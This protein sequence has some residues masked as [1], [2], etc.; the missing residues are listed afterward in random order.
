[1]IVGFDSFGFFYSD[2]GFNGAAPLPNFVP[3]D[4]P[5]PAPLPFG[6]SPSMGQGRGGGFGGGVRGGRGGFGGRGF[7]RGGGRG[8]R[9]GGRGSDGGRFGSRVG[10]GGR[11]GRGELKDMPLP[12][13]GLKGLIP[14]EKNFYVESAS[15]KAMS[16]QDVV[17]YR[18]SRDITVEG[19]DV[20]KPIRA[21]H[22]ANFPSMLDYYRWKILSLFM[23]F[24]ELL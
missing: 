16:E 11:S 19:R 23:V 2:V 14:F 22:D 18:R 9:G 7:D 6:V 15:V 13:E 17:L 21:F 1:M 8:G 3:F 20:P 5:A 24:N 10:G 4:A 12:L